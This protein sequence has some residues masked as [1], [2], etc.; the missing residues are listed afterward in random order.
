MSVADQPMISKQQAASFK[1]FGHTHASFQYASTMTTA[2]RSIPRL[3]Y[4]TEGA[5][6]PPVGHGVGLY[7]VNGNA[8][9]L[10]ILLHH[11]LRS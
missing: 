8:V 1:A 9:I 3:L 6:A 2:D 10:E 4:T 11:S 5:I 7:C